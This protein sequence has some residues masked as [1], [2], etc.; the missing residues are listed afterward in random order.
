M[1]TT[2][3][4]AVAARDEPKRSRRRSAARLAMG[5]L[6]YGIGALAFW[7]IAR[8]LATL[9]TSQN[10]FERISALQ[11]VVICI[12]GLVNLALTLP[13]PMITLP[14]L[15][16]WQAAVNQTAGASVS[17][18]VPEGG[19]VA[20]ALNV[21]VL[22]SWGFGVADITRG[23]VASNVWT[24][25]VRYCAAAIALIF[26]AARPAAPRSLVILAAAFGVVMLIVLGLL[27]RLLRSDSFA[28]A[29]GAL[30]ATMQR[31]ALRLVGR[32]PRHDLRTEVSDLRE[33]LLQLIRTRWHALTVAAAAS[34]LAGILTLALAL[35]LQDVGGLYWARIVV[36][37]CGMALASLI[38]P[39]PGGLG[40][41]EG[42]LLLVLGHGL[43]DSVT[44]QLVAAIVL[45]RTAT[46]LLPTV[47]GAGSYLYWLR[48]RHGIDGTSPAK[49]D[50]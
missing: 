33:H 44:P 18:T 50:S 21:T 40:V 39:T 34:Q 10:A 28:R 32:R 45:F 11:M 19:A 46:W 5:V 13:V 43:D 24:N 12:A 22:R 1:T 14:G 2:T 38:A 35:H 25:T 16:W 7:G 9:A 29:L 42:T 3:D 30:L 4:G 47:L 6:A 48:S 26:L 49:S 15:R 23:L 20:T 37:Y 8:K 31:S 27:R 41:A 17:N 36:A